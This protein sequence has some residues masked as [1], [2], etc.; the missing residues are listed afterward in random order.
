MNKENYIIKPN[1]NQP[2][3]EYIGY[4]KILDK[5]LDL[6]DKCSYENKFVLIEK[7]I[8]IVKEIKKG[9]SNEL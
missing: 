1:D 4:Y 8:E 6:I 9:D 5:I 7:Y 2:K 3:F